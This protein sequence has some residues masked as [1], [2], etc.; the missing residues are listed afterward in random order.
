MPIFIFAAAV[1]TGLFAWVWRLISE[2][3]VSDLF[4][5]RGTP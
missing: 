5:E 1:V 4:C 2:D 3:W